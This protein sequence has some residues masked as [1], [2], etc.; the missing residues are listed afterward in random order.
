MKFVPDIHAKPFSSAADT[1]Q[2]VALPENCRLSFIGDTKGGPFDIPELLAR[3]MLA[4]QNPHGKPNSDVVRPW[5]DGLDVPRVPQRK[6]I[7]D[8]PPGM[9]ER[10]A[11][12]YEQP[13]EYVRCHLQPR[14]GVSCD[15]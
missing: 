4:A 9:D 11:L 1:T 13:F 2:A 7:I 12:L 6:W 3:A 10:E 15:R 8:F 5:V 14:R